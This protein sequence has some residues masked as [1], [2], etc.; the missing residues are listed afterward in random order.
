MIKIK[1]DPFGNVLIVK[2]FLI[3]LLGGLC[4]KRYKNLLHIQG[5]ELLKDLPKK[6]V[7]FVSNHHTYFADVAAMF[8][9]FNAAKKKPI[10]KLGRYNYLWNT[11]LNLYYIAALETMKAGLL[12]KILA[13]TGSVSVERTWKSG[14]QEVNR[15]VR[16]SDI[17]NIGKALKDG[18][19]INFPQGTTKPFSPVRRGNAHII[20]IYQPIVVPIVIEG[21]RQAYNKKGLLI[22]EKGVKQSITFK[23]PLKFDYKNE[24]PDAIIKKIAFAIEQDIS[25]KKS[26][27]A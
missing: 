6:N 9:V 10:Q 21:F 16:I 4:Y 26:N 22:K 7:L 13:Y 3:F 11:K 5:S 17:E 1:K 2:R 24:D 25:F 14:G 27:T 19:V 23:A 18:W 15:K 12:P 20:K 8:H